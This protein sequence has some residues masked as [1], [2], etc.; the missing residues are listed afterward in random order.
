MDASIAELW[1]LTHSYICSKFSDIQFRSN[2]CKAHL[3]SD[4]PHVVI[5]VRV[6]WLV[7]TFTYQQVWRELFEKIAPAFS[8]RRRIWNYIKSTVL[9]RHY[10]GDYNPL[11]LPADAIDDLSKVTFNLSLSYTSGWPSKSSRKLNMASSTSHT[12]PRTI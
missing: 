11:D 7:C 8:N 3:L 9:C 10:I 5:S 6:I 2:I 1:T 12:S 4:V